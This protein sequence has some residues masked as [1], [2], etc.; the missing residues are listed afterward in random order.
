MELWHRVQESKIDSTQFP[1]TSGGAGISQTVE[2]EPD[3]GIYI[4]IITT[5][6]TSSPNQT[7]I[8]PLVPDGLYN[9]TIDWGDGTTSSNSY[10]NRSH[11]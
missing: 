3:D 1:I 5:W 2:P 10:A 11:T 6:L 9:G 8:L 4:P 7:I